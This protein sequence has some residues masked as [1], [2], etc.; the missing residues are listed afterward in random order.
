MKNDMLNRFAAIGV[1]VFIIITTMLFLN[2]DGVR[3]NP[4]EREVAIELPTYAAGNGERT[5]IIENSETSVVVLDSNGEL[6]K[7]LNGKRGKKDMFSVAKFAAI[8]GENGIYVLDAN[9]GGVTE[10]NVER[11]LKYSAEG[12]FAGELYTYRYVNED[13]ILTKGKIGGMTF[14]SGSIYIVRLEPEGFWLERVPAAERGDVETVMFFDY[15]NAFRDLVYFHINAGRG[16]LA[17][18]TKAGGIRQFDFS[19]TLLYEGNIGENGNRLPW[20]VVSDDNGNLV[21]ADIATSEIISIAMATGESSVLFTAPPDE[22]AYYRVNYVNGVLFAA[23]YDNVFMVDAAGESKPVYSYFIPSSELLRRTVLFAAVVFD[24]LVLVFLLVFLVL[25]LLQ[26]KVTSTLKVI[27]I[28]GISIALGAIIASLLIINEMTSRYDENTY[29]HLENISRIMAA[30][31]DSAALSSVSFP[32][33]YDGNEY[34]DLATSLRSTFSGLVFNGERVYQMLLTERDGTLYILYDLESSVGPFYPFEEYGPGPYKDVYDTKGY[35]HVKGVVTSEG[36][37]LFVCGPIFNE[38][39]EVIALLETGYNMLTVQ[40]DTR[41]MIIQ[42][43]LIV[44]AATVAILLFIIEFILIFE[45]YRKQKMAGSVTGGRKYKVSLPETEKQRLLITAKQGQYPVRQ[46]VQARLLL[47]LE[48]PKDPV[49]YPELLRAVVFFMFISGNLATALLP[50]YASGL[51]RPLFN[52]PREFVVTLPFMTDVIFAALA[53]LTI[54]LVSNKIGLKWIS[55]VSG[56]FIVAGNALCFVAASTAYLAVAYALTGFF[57]G[58]LLL[59]LN[60]IIGSQKDEKAVNSGF[61]HFNASY[62]AGVNV[63]V[64][65]GS[66]LA[67]FFPYRMV[68]LFS[69]LSAFVLFLILVFS[70]RSKTVSRI[71]GLAVAPKRQKGTFLKFIVNPLVLGTLFLVLLPYTISLSYTSY[72]MPIFGIENGLQESNIGQ[73]I[74]LSG[75]FAILFGTSLCEYIGGKISSRIAVIVSLLLNAG[76]ICLF[77][78][79]VSIPTMILVIVIMAI[80]NIF[81]LTNIQTYYA[82]LYQNTGISSVGAMSIYSATENISMAAGPLIFSYIISNSITGGMRIFAAVSLGCLVL[83]VLISSFIKPAKTGRRKDTHPR[84]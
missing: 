17:V 61:A 32:A 50:M 42:T 1:L 77:S 46:F 65:F 34:L 69:T 6:I 37:W 11:V 64:V 4:R 25:F 73:L 28:S 55:L 18:T 30:T 15:P 16:Q 71:Y 60:T 67:Q 9:F 70:V 84:E 36:S 48:K 35:V 58:A 43:S 12:K 38:S 33:Q 10:D 66:I 31:I 54:P 21:Y 83:F 82:T 3:L 51:Y 78:L 75:L 7:K 52:L 19:G 56:A 5:I 62:L 79:D 80:V 41:R 68:F 47:R 8:D 53:L 14:Y 13:F 24:V 45:A 39:G 76:A 2:R 23:S 59:V 26:K 40:E 49:F 22:S 44:L 74:L 27:L 20:T 72:F 81:A 29:T 63:G 57:S